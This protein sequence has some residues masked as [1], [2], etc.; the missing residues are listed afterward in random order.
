MP[1]KK[2]E[3]KAFSDFYDKYEELS[4]LIE[5]DLELRIISVTNEMKE[6]M[7]MSSQKDL[8]QTANLLKIMHSLL[9]FLDRLPIQNVHQFV[10]RL[11][12]VEVAVAT[13]AQFANQFHSQLDSFLDTYNEFVNALSRK[14]L[15]WDAALSQWEQALDRQLS[16]TV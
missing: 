11:A 16:K 8:T 2:K 4:S 15:L 10:N 3:D 14:F 1:G 7:I 5:N 9:S 12:V 13:H 6:A